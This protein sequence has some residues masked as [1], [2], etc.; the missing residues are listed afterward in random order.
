[1]INHIPIVE[2]VIDASRPSTQEKG[3]EIAIAPVPIFPTCRRDNFKFS[4]I[5]TL[6]DCFLSR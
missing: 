2:D 1:M 5:N 6:D 3:S 4:T